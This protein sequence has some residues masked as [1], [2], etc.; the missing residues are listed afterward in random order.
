MNKSVNYGGQIRLDCHAHPDDQDEMDSINEF[1][2][3]T[4]WYHGVTHNT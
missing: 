3:Y 4:G 1:T 2:W